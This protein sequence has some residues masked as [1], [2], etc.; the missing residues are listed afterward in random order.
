LATLN[1]LPVQCALAAV[2]ALLATPRVAIAVPT[3]GQRHDAAPTRRPL[4]FVQA[5]MGLVEI[6]HAEAGVF[7]TPRLT[8]EAM[9]AWNGVFGSRLGGGI[10]LALGHALAG[11]PPRHGWLLGARVMLAGDLAFDSHGDDL[12]SYAMLPVGYGFFA[13]NGFYFR[14]AAGPVLARERSDGGGH[15]FSIGGPFVTAAVGFWF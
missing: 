2:L 3:S 9:A 8:L 14:A 12:S 6:V 5:G 7:V 1:R 15:E 11:R 13:D 10:T 4:G